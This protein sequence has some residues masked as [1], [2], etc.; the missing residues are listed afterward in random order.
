[1]YDWLANPKVRLALL[2][3]GLYLVSLVPPA[4]PPSGTRPRAYAY[5]ASRV[6]RPRRPPIYV[7]L[8]PQSQPTKATSY[9]DERSGALAVYLK[10]DLEL[11]GARGRRL[12]LSPIFTLS[13]GDGSPDSVL[14]RFVSFSD[15]PQLPYGARF[16]ISADGKQVWPAYDEDGTRV[17]EGWSEE[18]VLPDVTDV[19]GGGVIE[20]AG[21]TVPYEVFADVIRAKRV[22]INFGPHL[23]ELNAEH[24]EALR[25]MHRLIS[26]PPP[27]AFHGRGY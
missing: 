25:D 16:V 5:E 14:L 15:K 13:E 26:Q 24:L 2:V 18:G 10:T 1:M 8:P 12:L 22:A 23:V 17:W 21:K 6:T 3:N 19:E 4:S 27:G 20:N 11:R 9:R 7:P